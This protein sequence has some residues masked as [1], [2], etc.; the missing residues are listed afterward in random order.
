MTHPLLIKAGKIMMSTYLLVKALHVISMVAWM[1]GMLYLPRLFVYHTG[2]TSGGELDNTLKVMERR[3]LRFIIN[4]AMIATIVFGVWLIM[5]VGAEN[6][7]K[8]FH[9]KMGLLLIL[10]AVHGLCV[11]HRK[12]FAEGKNTHSARYFRILNE[13]PTA[14]L[15]GIVI[16]AVVKPL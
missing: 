14:L 9:M 7:G 10:F 4:P 13:V 11:R 16:L 5:L 2:A 6:L 8:W 12:M 1:A 15:I 3:L